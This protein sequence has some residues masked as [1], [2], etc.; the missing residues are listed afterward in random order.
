MFT[1]NAD[2]TIWIGVATTGLFQ[3]RHNGV[4]IVS[5]TNICDGK[6]HSLRFYRTG[7]SNYI[8]VD[9]VLEGNSTTASIAFVSTL[10]GVSYNNTQYLNGI[11]SDVKI[12]SAG[13]L[14]RYYKI[15]EN[16][17]ASTS[18]LDHSGNAQHG[19]AVNI[20][21][22]DAEKYCFNRNDNQWENGDKSVIIPLAY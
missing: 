15:N 16:W 6:Q 11:L 20:T 18:L 19:T 9:G 1:T 21:S 3:C 10:L 2:G 13:T 5:T 14:E 4:N 8:E 12:Y 22:A 7:G 17:A